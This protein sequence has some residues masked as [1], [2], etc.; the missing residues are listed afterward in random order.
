MLDWAIV[1]GTV[2][3]GA[4]APAR[5][6]DVGIAGDRVAAITPPGELPPAH[7]TLDASG[8]AVAPGFI[9]PHT[10]LDAQLFWDPSGAPGADHG[11]T[12]VVIGNCGFGVAPVAPGAVDEMLRNLEAVEEI[13]HSVTSA[14]LSV[15]WTSFADYLDQLESLPL[16]VNV[17]AYAPHSLC[18]L[19]SGVR[20]AAEVAAALAAGAIGFSTSRGRNHVDRDG[21]PVASRA[22]TDGEL[23]QLVALA[24]GRVWQIN[25]AA[26]GATTERGVDEMLRELEQYYALAARAGARLTWTPLIVP[27]GDRHGWR[28]TLDWVEAHAASGARPQVSPLPVVGALVF[29]G[30][31]FAA[32]IEGWGPVFSTYGSLSNRDRIGRLES[33]EARAALREVGDRCDTVTSPCFGNWTIAVSPSAA[34]AVGMTVRDYAAAR[35]QHAIDALFDL[36]RAD[37]LA[38]VIEVPLSNV[39]RECVDRLVASPATMLGLGDAGAHVKTMANYS[40]PSA[41]LGG[42]VRERRVLSLEAAV[43][44]LTGQP[45]QF[46]GLRDRGVLREGAYADVCVFDAATVGAGAAEMRRDLPGGAARLHRAAIGYRAVFVNGVPRAQS[47]AGQLLREFAQ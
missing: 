42:Y 40:Y 34:A 37:E 32:L 46:F 43:H 24:A 29:D 21:A 30:P 28:R 2:V 47:T 5:L 45:A 39:D 14:A 27:P 23:A 31:S 7:H 17:A 25:V 19:A 13:P 35:G 1:G 16:G 20:V 11:V 15:R 26:K 12:T 18:R 22:A 6:A 3:D 36:A 9:D 8:H 41:V 44:K 10:H 38:T 4:G 33:A